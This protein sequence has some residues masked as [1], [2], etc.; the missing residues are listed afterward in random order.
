VTTLIRRLVLPLLLLGLVP[1]LS[2]CLVIE[3]KSLVLVLAPDSKEVRMYYVFEGLSVLEHNQSTLEKATGDLAALKT[4]DFS[5]FTQGVGGNS[6]LLEHFRF[7]KLRFFLDPMRKR[8]LCA[9]RR[10]RITDR[11]AFARALNED[12][13]KVLRREWVSEPE[14]IQAKLKQADEELA[15]EEALKQ[16][17]EFGVGPLIRTAGGLARI[18]TGFDE[19]SVI[20]VKAAARKGFDWVRFGPETI[21]LLF[22]TTPACARRIVRDSNTAKWIKEMKSFVNPI[23]VEAG[24]EGLAIVIGRK[25]EPIRLTYMDSR[26]Y[27]ARDEKNIIEAAGAPKGAFVDGRAANAERLIER[28][29]KQTMKQRK[30]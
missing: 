14:A 18:A 6:P 20:R 24:E 22:P 7:E 1:C 3:K 10:V 16:A 19:P 5:F 27:R 26:P 29:V 21:R 12:I 28:F 15:K 4:P 30:P 17:N 9:D 25:G 11:E 13:T 8:Q 2:G 23:D